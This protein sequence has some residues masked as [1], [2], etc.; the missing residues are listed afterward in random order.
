[1][2]VAAKSWRFFYIRPGKVGGKLL[3][4]W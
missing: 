2:A 4:G 1:L 3:T